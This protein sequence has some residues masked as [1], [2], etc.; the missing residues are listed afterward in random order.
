MGRISTG[1][2]QDLLAET[3]ARSCKEALGSISLG[4]SQGLTG[5]LQD[6]R[7]AGFREG[8]T[9]TSHRGLYDVKQDNFSLGSPQK[10]YKRTF[11]K[12]CNDLIDDC[13]KILTRC[14]HKC[15]RE[16]TEKSFTGFLHDHQKIFSAG[17]KIFSAG[18]EQDL[19]SRA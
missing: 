14:S 3:C 15:P 2:P 17:H 5:I 8:I 10:L 6:R 13:N 19:F 12:S 4:S 18:L 9:R 11:A 16:I 1:S 7:D